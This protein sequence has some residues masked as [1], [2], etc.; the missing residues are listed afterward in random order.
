MVEKNPSDFSEENVRRVFEEIAKAQENQ[1]KTGGLLPSYLWH[2]PNTCPGCGRCNHCGRG[3][4]PGDYKIYW[5]T[6]TGGTGTW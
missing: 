4:Y 1:P 5:V 3:G 2:Q 6:G